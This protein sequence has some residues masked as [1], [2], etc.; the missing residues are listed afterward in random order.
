[1]KRLLLLLPIFLLAGC[2]EQGDEQTEPQV[3]RENTVEYSVQSKRL[4]DNNI[5]L[6]TTKIIYINNVAKKTEV[7]TDTLPYLGTEKIQ[8]VDEDDE[9]TGDT[10]IAKE[11]DIYFTIKG[12][13]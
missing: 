9:V 7:I 5:L 11:Y 8:L 10:T 4:P 1:M 13:K 12:K 6:E 2:S 3:K